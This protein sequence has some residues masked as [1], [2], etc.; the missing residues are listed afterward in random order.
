MQVH[1]DEG[2]A[3]RIDPESCAVAREGNSVEACRCQQC[4]I[5]RLSAKPVE[6]QAVM[7]RLRK[8]DWIIPTALIVAVALGYGVYSEWGRAAL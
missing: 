2:V 3:T 7:F 4:S 1:H 8:R 5:A 6:K